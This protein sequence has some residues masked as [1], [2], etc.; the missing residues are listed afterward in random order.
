MEHHV[1]LATPA[2]SQADQGR[3]RVAGHPAPTVTAGVAPATHLWRR[4]R[5]AAQPP[6]E[7]WS[8]EERYARSAGV[9]RCSGAV[10]LRVGR[11]GG[12]YCTYRSTLLPTG[13]AWC[14]AWSPRL[15][16]NRVQ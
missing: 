9:V 4:D 8:S 3:Q 11:N 6:A 15:R 5:E 10:L 16:P 2:V 12:R 14:T 7:A 1:T 13:P